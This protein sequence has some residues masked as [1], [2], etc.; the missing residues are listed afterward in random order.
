MNALEAA[1]VDALALGGHVERLAADHARGSRSA[2]EPGEDLDLCLRSTPRARVGG[3]H[4]ERERLQRVAGED[5]RRFVELP[6][7]RRAAAPQIVVVHRRQVVVHERV[8]VNQLDGGGD[9]SSASSAA[10][11]SSP[12]A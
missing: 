2:R 6:V 4:L 1:L 7:S 3:E 12:L 10:P 11:T 8:G 5:R 9:A